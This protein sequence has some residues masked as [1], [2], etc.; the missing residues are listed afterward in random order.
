MSFVSLPKSWGDQNSGRTIPITPST[1][2][3]QSLIQRLQ[4]P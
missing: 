1:Q 4:E 3:H 2:P